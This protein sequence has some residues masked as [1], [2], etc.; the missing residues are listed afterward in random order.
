MKMYLV[1]EV[2]HN[3]FKVG[4]LIV[5]ARRPH[6]LWC[7]KSKWECKWDNMS[8]THLFFELLGKYS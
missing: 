2:G 1:R 8:H 4:F 7:P 6:Y 5:F 3:T